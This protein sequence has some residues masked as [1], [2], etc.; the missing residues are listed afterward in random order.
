MKTLSCG[1]LAVLLSATAATAASLQIDA[2]D[3]PDWDR[4][5]T[6]QT[7]TVGDVGVEATT[8][9][10]LWNA[11]FNDEQTIGYTREAFYGDLAQPSGTFGDFFNQ[12]VRTGNLFTTTITFLDAITD[13]IMGNRA[14][15]VAIRDMA[16]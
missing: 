4:L 11:T 9:L 3:P 15:D 7:G 13:P 2:E 6:T 14:I 10:G 8:T 16:K 1:L 12:A 5:A